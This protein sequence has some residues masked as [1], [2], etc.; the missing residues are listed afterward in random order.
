MT[1]QSQ[2]FEQEQTD[3][4][5]EACAALVPSASIK[6]LLAQRDAIVER[7]RTA[8]GLFEE[9]EQIAGTAFTQGQYRQ[10]VPSL[11]DTGLGRS[12]P[13]GLDVFIQCVD[14]AAWDHLLHAS[15]LRTFMDA[16]AR[17]KWDDN[18]SHREIPPLT[19]ENI[20]S[21]FSEMYGARSKMFED[22]VVAVYKS[23]SWDYKTNSPHRF[24]KRIILR[25]CVDV[26]GSGGARYVSGARYETCNKLDDLVRVLMLL[27]GK[28]EPDHR[29]GA[30]HLLRA[31]NWPTD[32]Q[33]VALH[34]VLSVRGFKNG[35]G[36]VTFLKPGLVDKMNQVLAKHYPRALPPM[37]D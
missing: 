13:E 36:H 1:A 22:G 34:D 28:P 17:K 11:R 12:F 5:A 24:G 21:T 10:A 2:A 3:S 9:I 35:N 14:A 19:E 15:G 27:D 30:Y 33:T 20:H 23:L 8:A 26:W 4:G 32:Q 29:Q 31:V 7:L 25:Y 37:E 16:T 18:I 6:S